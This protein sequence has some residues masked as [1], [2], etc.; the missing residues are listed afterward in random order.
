M[1]EDWV[2]STNLLCGDLDSLVTHEIV[3]NLEQESVTLDEI[4]ASTSKNLK[5]SWCKHPSQDLKKNSHEYEWDS[6]S[7]PSIVDMDVDVV[8]TYRSQ[9]ELVNESYVD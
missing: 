9:P 5:P 4:E 2:H 6:F 3:E 8:H 1:C 7:K